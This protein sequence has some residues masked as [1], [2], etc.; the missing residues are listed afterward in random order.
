M[1]R[2]PK[3][4][5]N[6]TSGIG[7][8]FKKQTTPYKIKADAG[9]FELQ[10]SYYLPKGHMVKLFNVFRRRIPGQPHFEDVSGSEFSAT[11]KMCQQ[12][13][14]HMVRVVKKCVA[15]IRMRKKPG[16][17]VFASEVSSCVFSRQGDGGYIARIVVKGMCNEGAG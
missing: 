1:V 17:K 14:P 16:F 11:E 9:E 6:K 4:L 13:G 8:F 3:W 5:K 12:L 2:L 7:S 15:D 10:L